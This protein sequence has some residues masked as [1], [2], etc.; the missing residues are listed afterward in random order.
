MARSIVAVLEI[1]TSNTVALIG[2][3]AEGGRVRVIGK[4]VA[5][6][7][8][9]RKGLIIELKQVT[10]SV[11]TALSQAEDSA[12]VGVGEVLLAVS[13]AHI[14]TT[15]GEG[16][17]PVRATDGKVTRDDLDAI[18]DLARDNKP[19]PDR[20]ILHALSQF[21]K[22]DDLDGVPNPEGMRG[23]QL[24]L[25]TLFIHGQRDRI[26][27]AMNLLK[28]RAIDTR[29]IVF[30]ALAAATAV[31]TPE[32]RNH[33]VAL[34]DLGGGT[35]NY[36]VFLRNVVVAAGSFGI[37]GDHVTNDIA[38]AFSIPVN[39]AEEFKISE[40]CAVLDPARS[41]R[42]IELPATVLASSARSI[43]VKSLHMVMEARLR[44]T[45]NL[46]REQ[47][48]PEL[49][50]AGAGVVF[51]GG[52]A[53][54]PR[55]DELSEHVFGMRAQI[56]EPLPQYI[57]GI[58]DDRL[59]PVSLATVSGMLIRSA[60]MRDDENPVSSVGSWV[61]NLAKGFGR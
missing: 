33:G 19:G 60:Q 29:D 35:T 8:G 21:Y 41:G 34:I 27:D 36:V 14:V 10:T 58:R 4:G 20:H 40:G 59:R 57:D 54:V 26:D 38:Q 56:G 3:P 13:G 49:R 50:S 17:L 31:L 6:T 42:R 46:V 43:S 44:E 15:P 28:G 2:E 1:G 18:R 53:S 16:R 32:Q 61:R 30:S 5:R 25:G 12:D 47:V 9:V 11:H 22:L 37:G 51:T 23:K 55:L 39:Q 24:R 48:G 7:T 52:G 45:L